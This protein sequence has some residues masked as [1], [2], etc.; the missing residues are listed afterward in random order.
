MADDEQRR[1]ERFG[2]LRTPSFSRAESD[3]SQGFLDKCQRILRTTAQSSPRAPSVQGSSVLG[4][5]C[6]YSGSQGP[7]QNSPPFFERDCYECGELGHVRKYCPRLL[8]GPVQQGSKA[9]TPAPIAPP[10]A[11]PARGGA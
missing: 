7:P 10:P 5:F 4:S 2:R 9:K 8:P 11:Q 3:T 1:L 6:S